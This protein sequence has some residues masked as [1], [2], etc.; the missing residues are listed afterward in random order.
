MAPET[1][2]SIL[3]RSN[4]H[5]G[6]IGH[7]TAYTAQKTAQSAHIHGKELLKT[8]VIK[9]DD[10]LAMAVV[11]APALVDLK[12]VAHLVGA[13]RADLASES[14]FSHLFPDSERGAMPP[15]G[16]LYD[17]PVYLDKSLENNEVVTFNGG[18]HSKL[19]Q[20]RYQDFK[21]FVHPI[22]E[23]IIF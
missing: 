18:S 22:I 4:I 19:I 8:V 5:Y 13:H 17:M 1:I 9:L 11:P 3:D 2:E 12:R 20:M 7:P 10:K 21:N 23:S 15:F 16:N 6:I 14:E